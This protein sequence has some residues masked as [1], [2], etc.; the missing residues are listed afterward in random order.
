[1]FYCI[2][3]QALFLAF[4][5]FFLLIQPMMTTNV[6]DH[7]FSHKTTLSD[8]TFTIV[9]KNNK[10]GMFDEEGQVIIPIAYDDLGWSKGLP[11]VFNKVIGY[12]EGYHWG[13]LNL[14]NEKVTGA[15]FTSLLPYND[16][17]IIAS[18]GKKGRNG[19]E[20]GVIDTNGKEILPFRY[21]SLQPSGNFLVASTL[22]SEGPLYG[23][24]NLKGNAFIEFKYSGMSQLSRQTYAVKNAAGKAGIFTVEGKPLTSFVYDSISVFQ[25]RLA[26]VF[27]GGR[28]GLIREDGVMLVRPEYDR[29]R[30]NPDNTVSALPFNKWYLINK[31]NQITGHLNYDSIQPAGK[32]IFKIFI[33]DKIENFVNLKGNMLVSDQWQIHALENDFAILKRN[34]KYGVMLL[35]K[36]DEQRVILEPVYDS[37][38]V[39][40]GYVVA[41]KDIGTSQ[42]EKA[43][44]VFDKEGRKL[45][46]YSYQK[47]EKS[48]DGFFVVKRKN[49]WG[50]IN[51]K[52][53]EIVPCQY[54]EAA[55]FREG[56]ARVDFIEG[57]GIIDTT[58]AWLVKPFKKNGVKLQLQY[59][60]DNLY[61]FRTDKQYATTAYGLINSN[62]D[63]VY[64][65]YAEL[66]DNGNTVWEKDANGNYG[67]V[68]YEGKRMLETKHDSISQLQEDTVYIF[69]KE[70][71]WGILSKTG[72]ILKNTNNTFQELQPMSDEY[73]GVKINNKFGFVDA[74]GRLRIANR[75]DSITSFQSGLS[76]VKI[77]GKWGY[78]NKS[79]KLVVQPQFDRAYSFKG[80]LAIVELNGKFGLVNKSGET[81][82]PLVY[83][84][85][86]RTVTG[87]YIVERAKTSDSD[88]KNVGLVSSE[89]KLLIYPKY[90]KLQD[91]GNNYV[92]ITRDD[93]YGLVTKFG[94]NK[95]PLKYDTLI[96]D[97]YNEIYLGLEKATWETKPIPN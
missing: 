49:H 93:N 24:I 4:A 57:Q 2:F 3:R 12:R 88:I 42:G 65:T 32:G 87:N 82:L 19:R 45:T 5:T 33:D 20:F 64:S 40:N 79:E 70:D 16:N 31:E 81:I 1:M 10:K 84:K 74:L 69:N 61:I 83:S 13:L 89:G 25:N 29:I 73:M 48:S 71:K 26:V 34:G 27:V 68:S 51:A 86:N 97:A 50:F 18:R 55:P 77:M 53:E 90:D 43:W 78:I 92:I 95:I 59:I 41:C 96:Y 14:K 23:L 15:E 36:A 94:E 56:K 76:A 62:E 21:H 35:E 54:I 75:Y 47:I 39:D 85:I 66:I 91:L 63:E 46:Y 58:G 30:V 80:Q 38:F 60:N 9:E 7:R 37:L 28:Q 72:K 67:L 6:E 11:E 8:H 22:Q 44:A 52:G 17:Y